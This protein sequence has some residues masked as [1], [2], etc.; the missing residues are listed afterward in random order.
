MPGLRFISRAENRAPVSRT[1]TFERATC[2][3]AETVAA[4]FV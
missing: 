4:K 1:R 2:D 3:Y